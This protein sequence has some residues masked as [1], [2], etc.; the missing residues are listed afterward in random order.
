MLPELAAIIPPLV[1]GISSYAA[2]Q[3]QLSDLRKKRE[4]E[5]KELAEELARGEEQLG[6]ESSLARK[7]IG[8]SAGA[9]GITGTPL[10]SKLQELN[11]R[12][13]RALDTLR[14]GVQKRKQYLGLPEE[15]LKSQASIATWQNLG[16]LLPFLF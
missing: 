2:Y 5:E 6:W 3:K 11:E 10:L 7:R 13:R 16:G 4:M 14:W 12:R 1:S 15:E 9:T 8:E